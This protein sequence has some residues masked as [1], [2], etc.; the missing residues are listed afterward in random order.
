[1]IHWYVPLA[2]TGGILIG[3]VGVLTWFTLRRTGEEAR[4]S[5][6]DRLGKVLLAMVE[7]NRDAAMEQL[8]MLLSQ[9]TENI[10]AYMALSQLYR[11]KGWFH[12]A[13]DIR[14]RLLARGILDHTQ[15]RAIMIGM[16]IDYQKAGLLGR[17]I[18]AMKTVIDVTDSNPQD[19]E[20]LA[21]LYE[22][23]GRLNDA[24][25]AW[26]KAGNQQNYAFVRTEIAR[27]MVHMKDLE[28]ARK[29][30]AH[31]LKIDK[32]NPAAL[33]LLADIMARTDRITQAEKLFDKLQKL[34][35]DLTGVIADALETIAAETLSNKTQS[36]FLD[37]LEKQKHRPRVAVRYA[38]YLAG[39]DRFDEARSI[40]ESVPTEELAPETMA[41]LVDI[42]FRCGAADA[43]ARYGIETIRRFLDNKPFVCHACKEL[44]FMLEWK[45]PKCGKWG[46][47]RS[48]RSYSLPS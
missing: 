19:I 28:G 7:D 21:T 36:F 1:M 6:V 40:I 18:N 30:L 34:R 5:T 11:D 29:Y 4:K 44:V 20:L 42:A 33:M 43:A 46:T 37:L 14:R 27:Q 26:K 41:R 12:R 32:N 47:I 39:L 15:R 2:V 25:E 3:A 16:V 31:T 22:Q 9:T 35:P 24:A 23:G 17:A 48:R 13:I 10:D 45:C 8:S 38:G